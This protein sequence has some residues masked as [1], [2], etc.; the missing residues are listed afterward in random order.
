MM[1]KWETLGM[2]PGPG[3]YHVSLDTGFITPQPYQQNMERIILSRNSSLIPFL[4]SPA[5]AYSSEHPCR[6]W[7]SHVPAGLLLGCN[8]LLL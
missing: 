7:W 5:L 3:L 4:C 6:L 1:V 8:Y 2:H